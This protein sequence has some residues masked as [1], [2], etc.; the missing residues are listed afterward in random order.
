M[1]LTTNMTTSV[2]WCGS[3]AGERVVISSFG[4]GQSDAPVVSETF[5]E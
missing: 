4:A 5:S 1:K 2:K 3:W